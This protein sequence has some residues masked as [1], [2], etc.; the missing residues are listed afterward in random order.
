MDILLLYLWVLSK[1]S[2]E[3]LQF[4]LSAQRERSHSRFTLP[5]S[6]LPT[7]QWAF[8]LWSCAVHSWKGLCFLM[9]SRKLILEGVPVPCCPGIMHPLDNGLKH[10]HFGRGSCRCCH[11]AIGLDLFEHGKYFPQIAPKI[12]LQNC[13]FAGG[14]AVCIPAGS[15]VRL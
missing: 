15:T 10:S 8:P 6:R 3:T 1:I 4:F 14:I 5:L 2:A 9:K 13:F 11:I 7:A 12:V